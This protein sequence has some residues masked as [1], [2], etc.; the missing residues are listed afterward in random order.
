LFC[1]LD[2][3]A[4]AS[5]CLMLVTMQNFPHPSHQ[6]ITPWGSCW[7]CLYLV[8]EFV[9]FVD[10]VRCAYPLF[11][12]LVFSFLFCLETVVWGCLILFS[13]FVVRALSF[14]RVR[15]LYC[16]FCF[17]CVLNLWS[18]LCSK[19]SKEKQRRTNTI[20]INNATDEPTHHQRTNQELRAK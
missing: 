14:V 9:L 13:V 1:V 12:V 8:L 11:I 20:I 5:Y 6:S 15:C 10:F 16:W 19:K 7:L 4:E 18:C 2:L 3:V 17:A